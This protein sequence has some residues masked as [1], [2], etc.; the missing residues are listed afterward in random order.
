MR[1]KMAGIDYRKAPLQ[2]RE[3]FSMTASAAERALKNSREIEGMTG[4]VIISTCNRTEYWISGEEESFDS[5]NPAELLAQEKGQALDTYEPYFSVR[6]GMEAVHY[7]MELSC[8]LRS[9]IFG[10]DQ[11]ITQVKHALDAA[12]EQ[13]AVDSVLET[14]FRT[15]VT[16]AKKV[17]TEVLLTNVDRSV[18]A[19]MA[20][21][22][23]KEQIP[24]QGKRCMVIGNGEIG[25]LA[26]AEL[27]K[28]GG[29]V[30]MTL[31]QYKTREA[32]IPA[33]C[34]VIDYHARYE[35]L[36]RMDVVVS[37]TVSPHYTLTKER[38]EVCLDGTEKVLVD[39]AIPRDMEP[40]L[41]ALP[42]IKLYDMDSFSR[43]KYEGDSRQIAVADEILSKYE[44]EYEQWYEFRE[45]VPV[46]KGI[47]KTAGEDASARL[48]KELKRL[49]LTLEVREELERA[50]EKSVSKVVAKLCY[51]LREE[52]EQDAWKLCLDGLRRSAENLE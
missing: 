9:Q 30:F 4:C 39:L 19:A 31:R 18:A 5:L 11:I 14:L 35:H 25:R 22:L 2:V 34:H 8:G 36:A 40:E 29:E 48:R 16:G 3:L 6:E 7:L 42:G 37:A 43:L 23:Q 38:A 24:I 21:L 33:G 13:A 51:G 46:V 45:F 41:A 47:S 28:A 15:A 10:D 12:R 44:L 1:I 50:I 20:L 49:G 52:L 32:I 17:K 26:A 27:V